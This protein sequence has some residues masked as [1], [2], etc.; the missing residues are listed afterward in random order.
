M[1]KHTDD[2]IAETARQIKNIGNQ[3]AMTFDKLKNRVVVFIAEGYW[4]DFI[5]LGDRFTFTK[6]DD[7]C[8]AWIGIP[9]DK[10]KKLFGDEDD[11]I[12]ALNRAKLDPYGTK[13]TRQIAKETGLS[14]TTVQER[15]NGSNRSDRKVV[16]YTITQYTKP[17]TAAQKIITK[18]GDE[19]AKQLCDEII[20]N[21]TIDSK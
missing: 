5:C 14:Q 16:K 1:P 21:L 12:K 17:E 9:L 18:F 13:S 3:S 19:F 11:I 20:L 15:V 7:F 2:Q 4:R 8:D 6:V 10:L